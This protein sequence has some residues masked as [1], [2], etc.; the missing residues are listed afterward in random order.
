MKWKDSGE[1]VEGEKD[2]Q[3]EYF[4]EEQYSPWAERKETKK[5][6]RPGKLQ[7]LFILLAVAIVALVAAL[8]VLLFNH[9]SDTASPQRMAA[10]EQRLEK[11]EERLDKFEGIDEKVTT[12]WE[13]AKSF[14]K[15]KDRFDRSEASTSLRMDHLTMSLEALQKQINDA[16]AHQPTA[17]PKDGVVAKAPPK[18]LYHQVQPGDTLY[19]I[20][21]KYD[22]KV[23]ELLQMN[24]MQPDSVILPGQK[25]I[26]RKPSQ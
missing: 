5:G 25:L 12:I 22:L 11:L 21:K 20:S 24:Q 6:F 2:I 14:E 26:V 17:G 18:V 1:M 7:M 19:S 15:F 23:E 13:Q 8:L 3:A 4:D 16:R 10:F 9:G